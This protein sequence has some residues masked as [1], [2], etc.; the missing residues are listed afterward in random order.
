MASEV[1]AS[2]HHFVEITTACNVFKSAISQ[3]GKVR[4]N[5][6]MFPVLTAEGG[7]TDTRES[8]A[9]IDKIISQA[10]TVNQRTAAIRWFPP[11]NLKAH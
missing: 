4:K 7:H 8:R 9:V 11:R 1:F 5:L 6:V 2:S 3:L 10:L